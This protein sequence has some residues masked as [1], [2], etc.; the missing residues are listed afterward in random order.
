MYDP[1]LASIIEGPTDFNFDWLYEIKPENGGNYTGFELPYYTNNVTRLDPDY[2]C[3]PIVY[4]LGTTE[5]ISALIGA[6]INHEWQK[7]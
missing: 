6:G 3:G 4:S 1:C 7:V 2:Y 5:E